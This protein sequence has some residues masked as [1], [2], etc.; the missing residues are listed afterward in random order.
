VPLRLSELLERIRPAGTP[1]APGEGEQQRERFDRSRETAEIAVALA[2]FEAEADAVIAAARMTATELG[3]D[4]ERRAREIRS[5]VPGRIATVEAS[6]A[7]SHEERD[8][9][10][11]TELA[12]Q[13]EAELVRLESRAAPLIPPLVAAATDAIW[14]LIELDA[15]LRDQR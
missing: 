1:G 5:A 11:R 10:E 14:A 3:S 2:A 8:Q 13:T 7:Q 9:A 12:D 6:A 15:P 4:A